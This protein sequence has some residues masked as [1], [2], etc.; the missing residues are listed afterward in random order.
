MSTEEEIRQEACMYALVCEMHSI[1]TEVF[2]MQV[3]NAEREREGFSPAYT[4]DHFLD[5]T[6]KFNGLARCFR[7]EI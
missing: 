1:K 6:E 4:E 3:K 2:A 7:E 5:C